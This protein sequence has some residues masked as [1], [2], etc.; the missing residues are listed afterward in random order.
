MRPQLI[1]EFMSA[2][3]WSSTVHWCRLPDSF[4]RKETRRGFG[5][6]PR[7]IQDRVKGVILR[8]IP[9]KDLCAATGRSQQEFSGSA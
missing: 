3:K 4:Q 2:D 8:S 6:L 9:T 5:G 1:V 7:E